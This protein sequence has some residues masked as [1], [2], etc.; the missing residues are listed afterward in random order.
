M[1]QSKFSEASAFVRYEAASVGESAPARQK[2]DP[3]GAVL[4]FL[5]ETWL[6]GCPF[7]LCLLRTSVAFAEIIRNSRQLQYRCMLTR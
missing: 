1:G 6:E 2:G 3:T 7:Y 4:G 5:A